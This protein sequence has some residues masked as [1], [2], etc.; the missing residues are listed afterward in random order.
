MPK[1]LATLLLCLA[2]LVPFSLAHADTPLELSMKKMGK[3][4]KQLVL[5]LKQPQE[6]SK[7][8]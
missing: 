5:D 2:T 3:A 7:P 4:Y 8:D 6:A 1:I